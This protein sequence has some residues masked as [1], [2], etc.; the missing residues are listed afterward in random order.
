MT[1]DDIAAKIAHI[2]REVCE[3]EQDA[4]WLRVP[5]PDTIADTITRLNRAGWAVVLYQMDDRSNWWASVHNS[6]E[7]H[8]TMLAPS[9][10]AALQAAVNLVGAP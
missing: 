9:P 5:W 1:A 7:F 8:A 10:L 3:L 4:E 2:R 6:D